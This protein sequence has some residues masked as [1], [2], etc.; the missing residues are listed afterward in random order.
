MND[1]VNKMMRAMIG[2]KFGAL[3][4]LVNLHEGV[5]HE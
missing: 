3:V 2:K 4:I 1:F 5:A